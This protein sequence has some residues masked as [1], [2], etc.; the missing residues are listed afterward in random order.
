MVSAWISI[1]ERTPRREPVQKKG[2]SAAYMRH[3]RRLARDDLPMRARGRSEGAPPHG[4]AEILPHCTRWQSALGGGVS[5]AHALPP[6]REATL[7]PPD[8]PLRLPPARARS[9]Y[10]PFA[11]RASV[12]AFPP[13]H[14][15]SGGPRPWAEIIPCYAAVLTT[16]DV[17]GSCICFATR[18][19]H[20]ASGLAWRPS[21]RS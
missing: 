19:T 4:L 18:L 12:R 5:A 2:A 16:L 11:S 6:A 9:P 3:P 8:P 20:S 17:R 1:V 13:L 21:L 10:T 7:S 15:S 14:S